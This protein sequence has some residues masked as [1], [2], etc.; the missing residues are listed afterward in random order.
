M[1]FSVIRLAVMVAMLIQET[2]IF[3]NSGPLTQQQCC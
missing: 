3:L 2:L 1:I